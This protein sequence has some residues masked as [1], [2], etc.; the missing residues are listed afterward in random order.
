MVTDLAWILLGALL[1]IKVLAFLPDNYWLLLNG[2][3]IA[4]HAQHTRVAVSELETTGCVTQCPECGAEFSRRPGLS[5]RQSRPRRAKRTFSRTVATGPDYVFAILIRTPILTLLCAVLFAATSSYVPQALA[6][7]VGGLAGMLAVETL[8]ASVILRVSLGSADVE[9]SDI[10][11]LGRVLPGEHDG[12]RETLALYFGL[13]IVTSILLYTSMYAGLDRFAPYAFEHSSTI[14]YL[15]WS[16]FS[17]GI[18]STSADDSIKAHL[19]IAKIAVIVQLATGPL[20][21]FWFASLFLSDG[22][23]SGD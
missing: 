16:Y 17:V 14:N 22:D 5:L 10:R 8:I 23:Q 2:R 11:A 12:H 3:E 7:A 21:V 19:A 4:R 6:G 1:S 15:D 20:L 9:H 18:A 13:L